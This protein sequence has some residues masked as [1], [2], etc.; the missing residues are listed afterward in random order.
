[1]VKQAFGAGEIDTADPVTKDDFDAIRKKVI[2]ELRKFEARAPFEDFVEDFV[3]DL[4][5]SL[6][7]KRLK[8]VKTNVEALFHE[9]SKAEK[10]KDKPKTA[11]GKP[12]K[13]KLNVDSALSSYAPDDLEDFDDF[14]WPSWLAID[15]ILYKYSVH[16][17]FANFMYT[18][19]NYSFS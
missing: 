1:M 12:G 11:K 17:Y 9:K 10:E 8:K 19:V 14:M 13:A 18:F 6:P 3:Q 15:P 16:K 2:T 7:S 4:C 5:L